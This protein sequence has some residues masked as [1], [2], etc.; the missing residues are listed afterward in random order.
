M[1]PLK[2]EDTGKM[3][4]MGLC[5]AMGIAYD[6]PYKYGLDLP[7]KLQPRLKK[8]CAEFFPKPYTHTAKKGARYDYTCVEDSTC[9][10]SAKSIK[11]GGG[12][13]APQ[14]IG[15]ATPQKFCDLLGIPF[16][17]VPD[18][19][20][21]IQED[22]VEILPH[23]VNHTFDCPNVYF[24]QEKET[25]K[26]IVMTKPIDWSLY[27][28]EWTKS[29]SEWNNSSTLKLKTPTRSVSL[30]E[31]QFHTKSRTNMAI[32]WCYETF[33]SVFEDHVFIVDF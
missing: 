24:N 16:T 33:L 15:Q 29:H 30:L 28:F 22:I 6:G 19:K 31:V 21:T 10:I 1:A 2:T 7:T 9:H 13:V 27:S 23:L 18:L 3:F 26:Y 12:M 25:I 4:E 11:K 20:R 32:R 5:M 14:V 17:S 8:L